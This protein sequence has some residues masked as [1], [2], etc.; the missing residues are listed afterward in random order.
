MTF[1]AI[2]R[3]VGSFF[4]GT[5]LGFCYFGGL[6]ITLKT[7]IGKRRAPYRLAVSFVVRLALVLAGF[8][9]VM[10]LDLRLFFCTLAGFFL[11]RIV[12]TRV[13]GREKGGACHAPYS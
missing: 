9:W 13:L 3:I 8:Y 11:A 5:V 10:R 6:W 4:G 1:E 12:L 7:T 2:W